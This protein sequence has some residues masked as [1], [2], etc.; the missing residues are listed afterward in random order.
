MKTYNN[1]DRQITNTTYSSITFSNPNSTI[2]ASRFSISY[3][4]KLMKIS[5]A[6][7]NNANTND[8][9]ATYDTDNQVSVYVSNMK[10]AVLSAMIGELISNKDI[11]NVCIELK[12]GLL[13]I[14]DGTD[15]NS[16]NV[17]ISISY[18]DEV[19]NVNEVVYETKSDVYSGAY[20]YNNGEYSTTTFA[21]L[22]LNTI[23]MALDEYYKASS[24]AVAASVMEA[25]MYKRN[26]Q[27]EL[28]KAIADKVGAQPA[29]GEKKP[30]NNKTFLSGSSS[31]SSGITGVPAGY[32]TSS[33]DSI[34]SSL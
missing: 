12:N 24:Y 32:E 1:N 10:A 23:R 16:K 11:H 2:M 28:I 8:A 27:Y 7:R 9:Y 17:C 34:A 4:N 18:A 31:N 13:K 26:G 20:N 29:S 3:F 19:G 22:E 14:S 30:F 33:F 25:N 6:L 21:N 15:Y 5:I